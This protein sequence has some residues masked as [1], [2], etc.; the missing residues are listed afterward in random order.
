MSKE[1]VKVL[2]DYGWPGNIRELRNIIERIVLLY[3][4]IEL[5][6][7][8]LSLINSGGRYEPTDDKFLLTPGTFSLPESNFSL[9]EIELEIVKLALK[10]YNNTKVV[11]RAT[12]V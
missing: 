1:A 7:E 10:K 6:S 9:R 2:H 8:H 11:R 5:R 3:D 4:E 12:S